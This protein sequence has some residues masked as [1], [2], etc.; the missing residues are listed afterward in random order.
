M[1]HE[2]ETPMKD[3]EG[4]IALVTGSGTGLG[5][6]M[7]VKLAERGADPALRQFRDWLASRAQPEDPL[8]R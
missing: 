5:R 7:A 6:S 3:L 8:P 1:A 2:K 4:R